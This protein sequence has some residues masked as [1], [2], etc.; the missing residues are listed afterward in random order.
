M[1]IL[2]QDPAVLRRRA[3]VAGSIIVIATVALIVTMI[4][5]SQSD[6]RKI[7]EAISNKI[8]RNDVSTN[9]IINFNIQKYITQK[10][11]I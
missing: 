1:A 7:Q 4:I 8:N 6:D 11:N 5:D 2:S 9:I 10:I 3:I